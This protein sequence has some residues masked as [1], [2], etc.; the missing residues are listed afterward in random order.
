[1]FA[2]PFRKM[3]FAFRNLD[4]AETLQTPRKPMLKIK[5]P[6]SMTAKTRMVRLLINAHGTRPPTK[7]L[8][9]VRKTGNAHASLVPKDLP[10]ELLSLP[11]PTFHSETSLEKYPL[12]DAY[13]AIVKT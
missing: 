12:N 11:P 4:H 1:M 8:L 3:I 9:K 10:S 13:L 2:N 6:A 5:V 7:M